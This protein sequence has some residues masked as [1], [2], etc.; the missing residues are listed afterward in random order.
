MFSIVSTILVNIPLA[1]IE[2]LYEI[3]Y[4]IIKM[5]AVIIMILSISFVWYTVA[6]TAA[7][8]GIEKSNIW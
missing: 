8:L 1:I 6:I 2:N 7:I 5:I 4:T 3:K